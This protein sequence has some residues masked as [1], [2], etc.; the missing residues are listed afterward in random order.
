MDDYHLPDVDRI[1]EQI[2]DG[3]VKPGQIGP[4]KVETFDQYM[5][6]LHGDNVGFS[7]EDYD[8]IQ[9]NR[10]LGYLTDSFTDIAGM[11]IQT[12][13]KSRS[14]ALHLMNQVTKR[15]LAAEGN[16][17]RYTDAETGLDHEFDVDYV[18]ILSGPDMERVEMME[19][20]MMDKSFEIQIRVEWKD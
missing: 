6:L 13:S 4:L 17:Y 8:F 3:L 14:R 15:M 12:W 11:D 16:T 10:R 9:I 1:V 20:T 5:D 19:E 2:L 18:E 7:I